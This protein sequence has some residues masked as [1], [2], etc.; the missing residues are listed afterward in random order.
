MLLWD[1][2]EEANRQRLESVNGSSAD[3]TEEPDDE[4]ASGG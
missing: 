3:P 1:V 2:D 4:E